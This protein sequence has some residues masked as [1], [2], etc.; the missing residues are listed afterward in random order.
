MEHNIYGVQEYSPQ[1]SRANTK[2]FQKSQINLQA[3]IETP[4]PLKRKRPKLRSKNKGGAPK[5]NRNALKDGLHTGEMIQTRA[6]VR[7]C[8]AQLELAAAL[9]RADASHIRAETN[10]MLRAAKLARA[11]ASAAR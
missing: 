3:N 9:V 4:Q 8:I 5:G 10:A 2:K 1:I 7:T 6:K 11:R